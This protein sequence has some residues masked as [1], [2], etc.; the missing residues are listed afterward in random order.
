MK[1]LMFQKKLTLLSQMNQN[2]VCFTIIGILK[3]LIISLN[4]MFVMDAMIYQ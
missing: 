3:T 1:E 4:H 2:N